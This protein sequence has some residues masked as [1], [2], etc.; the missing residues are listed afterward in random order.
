MIIVVEIVMLTI[1]YLVIDGTVGAT[2]LI[3]GL[4]FGIIF[5]TSFTLGIV[6]RI[7]KYRRKKSI[8]IPIEFIDLDNL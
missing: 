2:R 4:F 1:I 8:D 5:L 6:W 3:N 7:V